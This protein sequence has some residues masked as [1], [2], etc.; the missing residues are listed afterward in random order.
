MLPCLRFLRVRHFGNYWKNAYDQNRSIEGHTQASKLSNNGNL[1]LGTRTT[2]RNR[3]ARTSPPAARR[4]LF[5]ALLAATL[6][7]FLPFSMT[8]CR[9]GFHYQTADR[10]AYCLVAAKGAG[11]NWDVEPDFRISPDPR[12]RFS[13]PS[14]RV[15]PSLPSAAPVL[16]GYDVPD[17][18][19]SEAQPRDLLLRDRD[20]YEGRP[21][22]PTDS[23]Y[24]AEEVVPEPISGSSRKVSL[25]GQ[26][27]KRQ[28]EV[29]SLAPPGGSSNQ[30]QLGASYQGVST[31]SANDYAGDSDATV[32]LASPILTALIRQD[33]SEQDIASLPLDERNERDEAFT[34]RINRI[35]EA[36]WDSLPNSCKRRMLEFDTVRG[37]YYRTYNTETTEDQLD[38]SKRVTLENILELALINN[39]DYQTRKEALYRT[40]LRLSFQQFQYELRP[41]SRGNGTDLGYVHNRVGGIEV[42]RLSTPSRLG[43]QKSLYTAGNLVT[44]FAN[45][46]V[47]TFNGAS[48]YSSSVGSELLLD[49]SQPLIQRDVQFEPLTQSERDVVY[50]AR[51][52][53]QFRK[54]LFRDLA[55]RYYNLLLTYRRIAIDTQDY[56]S[57]LRGYNR[58]AALERVGEI[59][60]FQVDQFE[61]NA[62]SSRGS[63]VNSC[64]S[65]EGALDRLKIS[66]GLPTELPLNL[67]LSE[68]ENL[69]LR[70]EVAV[71]EEQVQRKL[72]YVLQQLNR[73]GPRAAITSAAELLRRMQNL[74]DLRARLGQGDPALLE[75]VNFNL[76]RLEMEGLRIDA[77]DALDE[78]AKVTEQIASQTMQAQIYGRSQEYGAALIASIETELELYVVQLARIRGESGADDSASNRARQLS[79]QLSDLS[80]RFVIVKQTHDENVDLTD[81]LL[82]LL[83]KVIL[84][85]DEIVS[86]LRRLERR[87]TREL[88]QSGIDVASEDTHWKNVTLLVVEQ[89]QV[90]LGRASQG[91]VQIQVDADE[92]IL[93]ALVQRLDLMNQRGELADRWRDI[94]YTGDSLKSA[95]NVRGTQ[96]LRTPAG[97]NKPLDF[98]FDDSTTTL[99]LE[100][101]TPLNRRAE[102]NAFRLALI[103]YNAALRNVIEAE[104]TIKLE[105]R[106]DLRSLDLDRNQYE[107][108]IA[109]AAL[110]YERVVSTRLQL[111]LGSRN[112][113]ARDFLEAQQ[114]YT[115]SL[116][117]VAQQHIGFLVDRIEFFLDLEQMQVDQLNFWP[118][119][120]EEK[121]PF[122]PNL[123]FAGTVPRPYGSLSAGPWYS[124]CM[125]RMKHA[126]GGYAISHRDAFESTQ[127]QKQN[128]QNQNNFGEEVQPLPLPPLVPE[129]ELPMPLPLPK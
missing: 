74:E 64:N 100:F 54:R 86:E 65:L 27:T 21:I 112:V 32:Q 11:P 17:L 48:G 26:A 28:T 3:N 46:V 59:P 79:M 31:A 22:E 47:L 34:L 121:Y 80:Q 2:A 111:I 35:P 61:Q 102:R 6:P 81:V 23:D 41:F 12:S 44:R 91:L 84:E 73:N 93:T 89:G 1:T 33:S 8:G 68:L 106:D 107:I 57:N 76:R 55:V 72:D 77:L 124:K 7:T 82:E 18:S 14:C 90:V 24:S 104:D 9:R 116:S 70:D 83:P 87:V 36:A 66:V 115:R 19:T 94:K 113:S 71:V 97:G 5:A 62:L 13:D 109:S 53:V 4:R 49:L 58:A 43:F 98:S 120:R 78:V 15:D 126:G 85:M 103:N 129:L 88:I 122:L 42:N 10:D 39:R 125:Q 29:V 40:A 95:V 56:F 128:S 127:E 105:I 30:R 37:E 45:D 114:A 117:S 16:Y 96:S 63:L 99:G 60:R 101:D 52:Y 110:A 20:Q 67:D 108:S 118:D 69:T 119:L 50:A 25:R 38:A 51:D 92:A 123:D 75:Q